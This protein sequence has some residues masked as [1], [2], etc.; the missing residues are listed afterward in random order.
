[1]LMKLRT[2]VVWLLFCTF[3][4]VNSALANRLKVALSC[5]HST[6]ISRQ[7]LMNQ[8]P[9][10]S[11]TTHL[12][13]DA[14]PAKFSGVKVSDLTALFAP[15]KPKILYFSALNEFRASIEVNDLVE[16]QP[17]IAYSINGDA[18]SIRKRGPFMLLYDLDKFPHLNV[19]EYHN[20]M[21]WQINEVSIE[22]CE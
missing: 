14:E 10:T 11:F 1:M 9:V 19:P 12:P 16:Y 21:I 8:F 13:W 22:E 3:A 20:K 7:E 5:E 17:I 18:I 6:T 2:S 4:N 15:Q